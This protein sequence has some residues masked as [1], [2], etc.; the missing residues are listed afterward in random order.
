MR[1]SLGWQILKKFRGGMNTNEIAKEFGMPEYKVE[2]LLHKAREEKSKP[3]KYDD[4]GK[5]I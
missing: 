4:W 1:Q 3:K 5:E 2:S